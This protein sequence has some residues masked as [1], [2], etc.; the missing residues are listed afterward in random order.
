MRL[1]LF[2]FFKRKT[3]C[4]MRISDWSSDVCSSDLLSLEILPCGLKARMVPGVQ[5][6]CFAERHDAPAL[7]LGDREARVRAANVD[8]D[9]LFAHGSPLPVQMPVPMWNVAQPAAMQQGIAMRGVLR[10]EQ[11]AGAE[12]AGVNFFQGRA[13]T[14]QSCDCR[15]ARPGPELK[16]YGE[17]VE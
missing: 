16:M 3:A 6:R 13:A 17:H 11:H 2:F 15:R 7:D 14:A 12:M 4:V 5:R 1:T 8:R 10:N 9:D